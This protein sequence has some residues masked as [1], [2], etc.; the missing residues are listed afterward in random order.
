MRSVD[1]ALARAI[2]R[3][4]VTLRE[5]AA[6]AVDRRHMVALVRKLARSG[7]TGKSGERQIHMPVA[8]GGARRW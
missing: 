2:R 5:A 4:Q 1:E 3:G 8:V 6:H 7:L